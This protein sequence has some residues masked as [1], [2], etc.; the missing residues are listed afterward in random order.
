[1]KKYRK[2]DNFLYKYC[3]HTNHYPRYISIQPVEIFWN[4]LRHELELKWMQ[5]LQTPHLLGFNDNIY[6][7]GYISGLPDF[8][9]FISFLYIRKRNKTVT[10]LTK[11]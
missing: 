7:E 1:M 4:I 8:Y 5:L 2:I 9:V 3:K 10:W 11:K 6:N